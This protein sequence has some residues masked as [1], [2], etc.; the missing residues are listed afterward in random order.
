MICKGCVNGGNV[1]KLFKSLLYK[2]RARGAVHSVHVKS[3]CRLFRLGA[4]ES[5]IGICRRHKLPSYHAGIIQTP[6]LYPNSLPWRANRTL[7]KQ[8]KPC[9]LL[10]PVS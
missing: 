5:D 7:W 6:I 4:D 10:F 1:W 3:V 2:K 9:S 8:D